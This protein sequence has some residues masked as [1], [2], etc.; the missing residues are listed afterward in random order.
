MASP[1][2]K[3]VV[4]TCPHCG[5]RYQVP[6]ETIGARGREVACANCAR[7]W[8]AEA[9]PAIEDDKL[10]SPEDEEQLDRSFKAAESETDALAD[11]PAALRAL[12]PKGEVPPPE[13]MRSIAEIRAAIKGGTTK[14]AGTPAAEPT[15]HT[16]RAEPAAASKAENRDI[17][18]RQRQ[19]VGKLPA[20]RLIRAL[21]I[22]AVVLLAGVLVGGVV[23]RTE[24][25]RQ[26]P[27]MA[28]LYAAVGLPVNVVGLEFGPVK[29]LTSR[30]DGQPV[31]H[32]SGT[33]RNS[34]GRRVIIPPLVVTLLDED[35]RYLYQW[36]MSTAVSDIEPGEAIEFATELKQPPDG[37]KQVRLRF[38]EEGRRRET[39][40]TPATPAHE[41]GH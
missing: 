16:E 3:S 20:M 11:V 41:A 25:V 40:S 27:Q 10:F 29:T 30:R 26:L 5:T 1:R 21:R 8:K 14:A 24:I 38:S 36:S 17:A 12:I 35:G 33:I 28:Q 6:P 13:V 34:A 2:P 39:A 32:V 19:L 18:K 15:E 7:T 9:P 22:T 23:L 37:A 4:I 31:L